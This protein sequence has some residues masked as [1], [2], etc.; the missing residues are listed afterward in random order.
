MLYVYNVG[1]NITFGAN[2][3]MVIKLSL[4]SY[5]DTIFAWQMLN[6]TKL[7]RKRHNFCLLIYSQPCKLASKSTLI[8]A[9]GLGSICARVIIR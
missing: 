7:Q 4:G 8:L 1:A 3:T 9:D 5:D 6:K 2:I